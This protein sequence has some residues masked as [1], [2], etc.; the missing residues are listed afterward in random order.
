LEST[1]A[2]DNKKDSNGNEQKVKDSESD[3]QPT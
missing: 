2:E 1:S 3:L